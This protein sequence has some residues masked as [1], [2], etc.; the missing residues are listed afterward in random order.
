MLAFA[1]FDLF[2]AWL[3]IKV[4]TARVPLLAP[5]KALKS[6]ASATLRASAQPL[7]GG[8]QTAEEITAEYRAAMAQG[9]KRARA[10]VGAD[11]VG[12]RSTEDA[13]RQSV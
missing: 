2:H 3:S 13:A 9:A 11:D 6:G 1:G 5:T 8:T 12:Q 10:Q 7:T 4:T